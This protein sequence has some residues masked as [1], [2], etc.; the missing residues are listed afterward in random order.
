MKIKIGIATVIGYATLA[1]GSLPLILKIIQEGTAIDL[2]SPEAAFALIGVI[3]G[4]ITS[5]GR[6]AQAHAALSSPGTAEATAEL[7]RLSEEAQANAKDL[8]SDGDDAVHEKLP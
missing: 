2:N 3:L 4:G 8:P 1:A 7:L 5:I 6:Y